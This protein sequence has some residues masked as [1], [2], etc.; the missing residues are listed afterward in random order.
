MES[1]VPVVTCVVAFAGFAAV[2]AFAG[3]VVLV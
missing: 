3:S 2:E 1:T